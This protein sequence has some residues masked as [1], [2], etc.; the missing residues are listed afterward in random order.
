MLNYLVKAFTFSPPMDLYIK[1]TWK[2]FYLNSQRGIDGL[3]FLSLCGSRMLSEIILGKDFGY[4]L[5][6]K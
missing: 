1:L 4:I 3:V 6:K 2:I 5:G